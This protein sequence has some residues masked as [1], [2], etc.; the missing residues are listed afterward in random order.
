MSNFRWVF[1]DFTSILYL[2]KLYQIA[3]SLDISYGCFF[4]LFLSLCKQKEEETSSAPDMSYFCSNRRKTKKSATFVRVLFVVLNKNKFE[5]T[6][7]KRIDNKY[8][9]T[10][11]ELNFFENIQSISK[12]MTSFQLKLNSTQRYSFCHFALNYMQ[13]MLI[14]LV[15]KRKILISSN[16][17]LILFVSFLFRKKKMMKKTI[18]L[19][20]LRMQNIRINFSF[21]IFEIVSDNS[22]YEQ[23]R[24]ST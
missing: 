24:H 9:I 20:L 6:K 11:N 12:C 13:T 17:T 1:I 2:H 8:V 4:L 22:R 3:H 10:T 19:R 23:E 14:G 5:N 16:G 21:S 7:F 18:R 15:V